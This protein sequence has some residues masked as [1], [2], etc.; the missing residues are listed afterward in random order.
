V[1]QAS[2]TN[3]EW[4]SV[5]NRPNHSGA[6]A[7]TL[8]VGAQAEPKIVNGWSWTWSLRFIPADS[9]KALIDTVAIGNPERH[10]RKAS[11]CGSKQ[12]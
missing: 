5:F 4:F 8:N 6:G 11:H 9:C 12:Q 1:G 3:N 10:M 7:K 2:C